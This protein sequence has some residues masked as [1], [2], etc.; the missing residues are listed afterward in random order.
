MLFVLSFLFC[1][2]GRSVNDIAMFSAY[3]YTTAMAGS[4]IFAL[5]LSFAAIIAVIVWKIKSGELKVEKKAVR[6]IVSA[7][8]AFTILYLTGASFFTVKIDGDIVNDGSDVRVPLNLDLF[9]MSV[10]SAGMVDFVKDYMN[11]SKDG[12]VN[13]IESALNRFN[14]SGTSI[15]EDACTTVVSLVLPAAAVSAS[16]SSEG[17]LAFA[18][19]FYPII[20]LDLIIMLFSAA[21]FYADT[22]NLLTVNNDKKRHG[23]L[24]AWKHILHLVLLGILALFMLFMNEGAF[25]GVDTIKVML[26]SIV[27]IYPLTILS[28]ISRPRKEKKGKV[29]V[30]SESNT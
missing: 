3:Y 17:K 25:E 27:W 23:G 28:L 24:R 26:G 22:A 8:V 1:L 19:L 15:G 6:R 4:A 20:I 16:E 21:I 7:V 2:L 14:H 18:I 13:Q 5:V 30:N 9:G 29:N 10:S 11:T 12:W